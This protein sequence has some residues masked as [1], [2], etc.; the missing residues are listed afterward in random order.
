MKTLITV[1][2]LCLALAASASYA[3]EKD[4]SKSDGAEKKAAKPAAMPVFKPTN[5]GAP[6]TR[7]GGA[8]RSTTG[9]VPR[10]E[11]LVPEVAGHTLQAQPVLYW[12]LAGKTDD[13]IDFALIGV[14]PINPILETTLVGPFEPGIQRIRLADHDATLEPNLEYQ[15]F[16]RVIPNPEQRLYDRVIGGGIQRL[17]PSAEL[18][19]KLA[20]AQQSDAHFVL[21]EAGIWYDALDSLSQQIEAAPENKN[22]RAQRTALF[23]QVGLEKLN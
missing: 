16:V 9:T 4:T 7:L 19:A 12:Y 17:E 2:A 11:A 6:M 15:W 18:N 20:A 13:R 1:I 22:L 3:A 14:D 10:T 21:A 8:T 23:D 5:V